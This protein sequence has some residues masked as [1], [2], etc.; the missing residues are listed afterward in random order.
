[1]KI[2]I[3]E[4]GQL[5]ERRFTI[6]FS[7]TLPVDDAVKPVVGTLTVSRTGAGV[8]IAGN[9]KT[10]LKLTCETCWRQYFQALSVDLDELL[11][12]YRDLVEEFEMGA[13]RE[14]E[15]LKN[16]FYEEIG[17]DGIIDISDVVY[18]AVTLASPVFCR[19]GSDCSGPPKPGNPDSAAVSEDGAAG[20]KD[21]RPIDPRWKNLKTLFP[22]QD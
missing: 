20:S 19:C 4:L 21:E 17:R 16:D 3:D 18:Q 7:E 13:P 10:L 9:V 22:K 14:K 12:P 2:S 15:L 5:G 1:M 6:D 11:V 8:K